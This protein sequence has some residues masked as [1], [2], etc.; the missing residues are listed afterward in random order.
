MYTDSS[1]A[2]R[3][4]HVSPLLTRSIEFQTCDGDCE[5]QQDAEDKG[6][7]DFEC[8][9][10]HRRRWFLWRGS[11]TKKN[12]LRVLWR[13]LCRNTELKFRKDNYSQ[14]RKEMGIYRDRQ[15]ARKSGYKWKTGSQITLEP[16]SAW[17][18][19]HIEAEISRETW[20]NLELSK[21]EA[22]YITFNKVRVFTG[23]FEIWAWAI[24]PSR[25][26]AFE[27]WN[28]T[29]YPNWCG[30]TAIESV[31]SVTVVINSGVSW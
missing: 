7:D 26:R 27:C 28:S 6:E 21:N 4:L 13:I 19:N 3:S 24:R 25:L 10:L 30:E 12:V 23:D 15:L 11:S 18:V 22:L 14:K 29:L 1:K 17:F 5:Q 16:E 2:R 8:N 20:R 31:P 9:A